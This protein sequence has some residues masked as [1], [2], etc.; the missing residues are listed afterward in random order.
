MKSHTV[1][2]LTLHR[3]ERER[4]Q[5]INI[6]ILIHKT[7]SNP[8]STKPPC[9]WD[10]CYSRNECN[11]W[12]SSNVCHQIHLQTA[13]ED[14]IKSCIYGP[15]FIKHI[16]SDSN[17][18]AGASLYLSDD[19]ISFMD[20]FKHN[21]YRIKRLFCES[22][23]STVRVRGV[24]QQVMLPKKSMYRVQRSSNHVTI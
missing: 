17:K 1:S 23:V 13:P 5:A 20:T 9:T 3:T 16:W 7:A 11:L 2:L 8:L 4:T 6:F 24:N 21:F 10:Q 12:I 22:K 18:S 14:T 19:F 15:F